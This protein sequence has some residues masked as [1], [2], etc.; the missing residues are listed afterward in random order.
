M[1]KECGAL[2]SRRLWGGGN[3]SPPKTT[4][5]EAASLLD[6]LV[7]RALYRHSR[8]LGSNPVQA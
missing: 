8:G 6:S 5:W 3:T 2:V 1:G 7:G 4:T